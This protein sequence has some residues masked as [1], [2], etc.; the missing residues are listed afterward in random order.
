MKNKRLN[1]LEENTASIDLLDNVNED[2]TL[3]EPTESEV[4][5]LEEPEPVES[6]TDKKVIEKN[7]K[8]DGNVLSV[9]F[10]DTSST[11]RRAS[12]NIES[13]MDSALA[14]LI[15][16]RMQTRA[17]PLALRKRLMYQ[18]AISA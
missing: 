18:R 11:T 10:N 14:G 13:R 1:L 17:L 16:Q 5:L 4:C 12:S 8:Y 3:L 9:V 6:L 2:F 7:S 15:E